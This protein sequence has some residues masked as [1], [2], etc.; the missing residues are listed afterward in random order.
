[1]T[2]ATASNELRAGDVAPDFTL[3]K[4]GGGTL[5][6]RDLRGCRVILYFYPQDDTPGC[7][8]EAC[9]F[10]D[11]HPQ[12]QATD[13][14]VLG[15]SPDDVRSH[16]RFASKYGLPFTLLADTDHA[17]AERYGVWREKKL[18]GKTYMGIERSTFLID[19]DGRIARIWRKVKA[20][21]HPQEVLLAVSE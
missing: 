5:S 9:A 1:M 11:L 3:P 17:V 21:P 16:D 4:S 19:K 7:T 18:Y 6:L 2:D 13:T 8:K 10:R 12:L 14:V 20:E 15:I